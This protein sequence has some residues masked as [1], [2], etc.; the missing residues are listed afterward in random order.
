MKKSKI[1]IMLMTATLCLWSCRPN[2]VDASFQTG[3]YDASF[4]KLELYYYKSQGCKLM[5][6]TSMD[7]KEDGTFDFHFNC[8]KGTYHGRYEVR[9]DTILLFDV[10]LGL[11]P[12]FIIDNGKRIMGEIEREGV[13]HIFIYKFRQQ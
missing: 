10:N 2:D 9:N 13:K 6:G 4:D 8:T 5:A 1:S 11:P 12:K 3:A 7:F